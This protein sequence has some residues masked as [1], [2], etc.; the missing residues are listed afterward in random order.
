M[1][2]EIIK[3]L[4]G[5]SPQELAQQREQQNQASSFQLA[6]LSP[7]QMAQFHAIQGGNNIRS[8]L[9]SLFNVQDPQMKEASLLDG[10]A[11]K[12][13]QMG[14]DL[15]TS[16]GLQQL[17]QELQQ[18]GASPESLQRIGM[19]AQQMGDQEMQRGMLKK[20]MER[21]QQ[22]QDVMA[23]LP[24]G[25]TP[26]QIYQATL[27]FLTP[28]EANKP[29]AYLLRIEAEQKA[30][31]EKLKAQGA[32]AAEL[33]ALR[34]KNRLELERLKASL[35]T[36][37]VSGGGSS[38]GMAKPAEIKT[39]MGLQRAVDDAE[40]FLGTTDKALEILRNKDGIYAGSLGQKFEM[41]AARELGG[42]QARVQKTEELVRTLASNVLPFL[43]KFK[44]A[45]DSDIRVIMGMLGGDIDLN[46]KTIENI[47]VS[48]R[49]KGQT[50]KQRAERDLSKYSRKPA[51]K[52]ATSD[53]DPLGLR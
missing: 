28:E 16:K 1:A 27:P 48:W 39:D 17:A 42:N 31:L 51:N 10:T 38:E 53:N 20:N 21:E 24:T 46:P 4:F 30:A 14:V 45:S 2:G 26:E 22:M 18:Q 33:E 5:I 34:Q 47:L 50:M 13:S 49:Q 6:Q 52:G 37:E 36:S 19:A 23:N 43:E 7:E 44:P 3:G 12:L 29:A 25:A 11:R 8:G 35:K 15:N 9:N 32:S 40:D 41:Y